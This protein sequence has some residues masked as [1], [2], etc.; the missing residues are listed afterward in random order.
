MK[1]NKHEHKRNARDDFR[2]YKRNIRQ[3]H[4]RAASDF[5]ASNNSDRSHQTKNSRKQRRNPGNDQS[6]VKSTE[7]FLIFKKPEIPLE[8]KPRPNDPAFGIIKRKNH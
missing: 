8:S 6:V 7:N 1:K 3:A 4:N 5:F 2:V